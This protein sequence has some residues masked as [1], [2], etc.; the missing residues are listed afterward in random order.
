MNGE[1]R[2]VGLGGGAGGGAW[3]RDL[4]WKGLVKERWEL[5]SYDVL[6]PHPSHPS[7]PT[8]LIPTPHN[9]HITSQYGFKILLNDD[10]AEHAP[11][12]EDVVHPDNGHLKQG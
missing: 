2:E 11:V 12:D 8:H 3:G 6:N 10:K 5:L 1:G 4:R 9:P 7:H